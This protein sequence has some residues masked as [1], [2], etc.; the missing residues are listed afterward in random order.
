MA[1]ATRGRIA[2]ELDGNEYTLRYPLSAMK[3]LQERFKVKS[4]ADVWSTMQQWSSDDWGDVLL[5]GLQKGG[6]PEMTRE[7]VDDL[8]LGTDIPYYQ[9]VLMDAVVSAMEGRNISAR[10]QRVYDKAINKAMERAEGEQEAVHKA[11]ANP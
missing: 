6:S 7:T 2:I 9:A 3:E 1:N 11:T 5:L 10:T 8:V 4:P